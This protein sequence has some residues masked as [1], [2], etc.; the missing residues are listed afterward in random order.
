MY[1]I[2]PSRTDLVEEFRRNPMGPHGAELRLLINRLRIMPIADRHIMVCTRRGR[3]WAVGRIPAARG[4]PIELRDGCV[5]ADYAAA[6][7]EV[8]RLRWETATGVP[9]PGAGAGPGAAP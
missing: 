9:A 5:F 7:W 4:A 6:V 1:E 3:Q 2:D 8:F